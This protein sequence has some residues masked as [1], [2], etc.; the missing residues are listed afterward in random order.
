MEV[1]E[2]TCTM[3]RMS[4]PPSSYLFLANPGF[5]R[6]HEFHIFHLLSTIAEIDFYIAVGII[7]MSIA[8]FNMRLSGF[9]SR[10]WQYAHWTFFILLFC[11]TI[12]AFCLNLFKCRP[13]VASFN[14]IA[15]GKL[16][17]GFKCM[18]VLNLNT[19]LRSFNITMDYCLLAVPIIILWRTR[20]QSARKFRLFF[21]FSIGALA[22]IGSVMS[23]VS[24]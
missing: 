15:A 14:S 24:K 2:N 16:P 7:K 17:N 13:V 23:L 5:F 18:P 4:R 3:S 8:A 9:T 10:K 19:V 1:V 12:I 20:L 22:C 21:A 6:Y 11:Y